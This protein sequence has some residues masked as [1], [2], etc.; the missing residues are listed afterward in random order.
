MG[1]QLWYHAA[2]WRPDPAE[3]LLELQT[4]FLAETY[5]L[6]SLVQQHVD[7]ARE[8]VRVTEAEGDEYGLLD[9]YREELA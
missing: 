1:A 3:A 7:S 8:A 4:R 6:H 5:D 2:P 9:A